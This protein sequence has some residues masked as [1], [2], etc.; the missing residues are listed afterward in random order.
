MGS[1]NR[2]HVEVAVTLVLKNGRVSGICQR[3]RMARAQTGQIVLIAA[4][5]LYHCPEIENRRLV[6]VF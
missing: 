4:K 2:L 6:E 5:S 1:L 3:T